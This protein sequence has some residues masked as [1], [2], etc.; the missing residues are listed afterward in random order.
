MQAPRDTIFILKNCSTS[1][2]VREVKCEMLDMLIN[3]VIVIV[4]PLALQ[5]VAELLKN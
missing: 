1:A 5:K 4:T 2:M 3:W